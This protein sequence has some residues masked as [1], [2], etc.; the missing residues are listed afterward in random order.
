MFGNPNYTL[1][2]DGGKLVVRW[3][4]SS[5]PDQPLTVWYNW[6]GTKFVVDHAK[7]QFPFLTSYDCR[8]ATKEM[9]RAICYSPSVAALDLELGAS[10]A[11]L[12]K[13]SAQIRSR[14][15][16]SSNANGSPVARRHVRFISGGWTA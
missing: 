5:D 1:T 4:D 10:T 9:D 6:N 14:T 13:N 12:Y 11:K 16:K 2:V 15:F 3:G 8:K 7:L